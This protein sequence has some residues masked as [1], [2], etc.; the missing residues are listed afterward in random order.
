MNLARWLVRCCRHG[1][2][3]FPQVLLRT[4]IQRYVGLSVSN[5][6]AKTQR[7]PHV[8]FRDLR[9]LRVRNTKPLIYPV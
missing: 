7:L 4:T 6:G 3:D 8:I 9:H 1:G 5:R 2:R